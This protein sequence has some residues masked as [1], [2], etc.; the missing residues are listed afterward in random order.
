M[1]L[2]NMLQLQKYQVF[3]FINVLNTRNGQ[4]IS[5]KFWLYKPL[6]YTKHSV[7]NATLSFLVFSFFSIVTCPLPKI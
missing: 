1:S 6:L 3:I 7:E 5:Y 4:Q 2:A